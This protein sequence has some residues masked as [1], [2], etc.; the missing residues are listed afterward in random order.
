MA[1]VKI[2]DATPGDESEIIQLLKETWLATYPN[3][4]HSITREDILKKDWGSKERL[5]KWKKIIAE[6]GKSGGFSFVAKEGNKIVGFC[7]VVKEKDYNELK[8]IYVLPEY[9]GKGI[10]KMLANRAMSML[11]FSKNTIIEVVEY[12]KGAIEFYKKLGF[13]EFEKGKGHEVP[14]GKTM[15]TIK[16]KMVKDIIGLQKE[17]IKL[18]AYDP[19]WAKLY[20]IE[21]KALYSKLGKA[22]IEIQHIG[23]TSIPGAMTKPII[24]IAV[25]V[26]D[27]EE[28]EICAEP[29]KKL[30]YNLEHGAE[31]GRYFFTKEN[32]GKITHHLHIEKLDS[33]VWIR[34]FVFINYLKK[35]KNAL[36]RYNRFKI[37]LA[38]KNKDNRKAYVAAKVKF[39]D[40][41]IAEAKEIAKK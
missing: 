30:G 7:Q 32:N 27:L 12:N 37:E 18:F 19:K 6:N 29:L 35:N 38:E 24:D 23:S 2:L 15:P 10:G 41:M 25:G 9:Q 20:K 13:V 3:E 8:I 17:E 31:D 16:M 33:D 34:Q 4:E 26:K 39:I 28:A 36:D 11:D 1:E 40:D 14:N 22:A 5:E 21:E